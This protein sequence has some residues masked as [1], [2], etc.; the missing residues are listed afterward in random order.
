MYCSFNK[1]GVDLEVSRIQKVHSSPEILTAE[2]TTWWNTGAAYG[3]FSEP[4]GEKSVSV[5]SRSEQEQMVARSNG[6]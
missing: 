2:L 3:S 4:L 1:G 6:C 5:H